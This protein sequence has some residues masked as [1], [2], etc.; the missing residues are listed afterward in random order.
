MTFVGDSSVIVPGPCS[1]TINSVQIGHTEEN[2]EIIMEESTNPVFSHESR[3]VPLAVSKSPT[4]IR[5]KIRALEIKQE[6]LNLAFPEA[7]TVVTAGLTTVTQDVYTELSGV[8]VVV[9]PESEGAATA[10]DF[11]LNNA[12]A[13][14]A[15]I[16]Q[17]WGRDD[18]LMLNLEFQR[19]LVDSGT[20]WTLGNV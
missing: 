7:S 6:T 19:M 13:V 1:V 8:T 11:T 12:V 5:I 16:N 9:H 4:P 14:G 2:V 17:T 3:D 10:R 15:P 18:K 20:A